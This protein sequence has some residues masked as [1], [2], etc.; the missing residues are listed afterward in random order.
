[1][2]TKYKW[3]ILGG[4]LFLVAYQVLSPTSTIGKAKTASGKGWAAYLTGGAALT[5]AVS[6]LW[7]SVA[8][9]SSTPVDDST[10]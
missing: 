10:P 5:N 4:L 1:M 6:N 7:D 3:W 8:S 2:W 9:S